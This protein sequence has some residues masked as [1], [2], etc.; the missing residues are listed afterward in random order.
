MDD[1]I[2]TGR[3]ARPDIPARK[4]HVILSAGVR[5]AAG[6]IDIV[7]NRPSMH[8]ASS[9]SCASNGDRAAHSKRNSRRRLEMAVAIIGGFQSPNELAG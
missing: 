6:R 4:A 2:A 1:A 7:G 8:T 3:I 5:A 9:G